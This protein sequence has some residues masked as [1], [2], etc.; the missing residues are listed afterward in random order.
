[1]VE[2]GSWGDL[3][4]E[5]DDVVAADW[6]ALDA[7]VSDGEDSAPAASAAIGISAENGDWSSL[8][9][10]DLGDEWAELEEQTVGVPLIPG[11]S[12]ALRPGSQNEQALRDAPCED[13]L[14]ALA[15][16][17]KHLLATECSST[18]C[19][20]REAVVSSAEVCPPALALPAVEVLVAQ[21]IVDVPA[22]EIEDTPFIDAPAPAEDN[23][24]VLAVRSLDTEFQP[25][26][27]ALMDAS[28]AGERVKLPASEECSR[29]A[30][31]FLGHHVHIASDV[32]TA[33]ALDTERRIVTDVRRR[34]AACVYL[35]HRADCVSTMTA[36][37]DS[38]ERGGGKL[39]TFTE[40]IR[41]D[42]T[43]LRSTMVQESSSEGNEAY[44]WSLAIVLEVSSVT[45]AAH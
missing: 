1:M 4:C 17:F 8:E 16:R 10:Q 13:P 9:A 40:I 24:D 30:Q 38:I 20:V 12:S 35:K 41:A 39:I 34:T 19:R 33:A 11:R 37:C 36:F 32:S 5:P 25:L 3:D 44:Q 23:E 14:R 7:S 18:P 29:V 22:A 6:E 31:H 21:I 2:P 43:P 28:I 27:V 15:K 42:E 26:G 45:I